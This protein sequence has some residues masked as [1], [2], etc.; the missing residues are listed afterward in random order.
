MNSPEIEGAADSGLSRVITAFTETGLI[1]TRPDPFVVR[2]AGKGGVAGKGFCHCPIPSCTTAKGK[3]KGRLRRLPKK[4]STMARDSKEVIA[5][6][7]RKS[8]IVI[9]NHR[10]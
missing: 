4:F 3:V 8:I 9:Y 10:R 2:L 5:A 6:E 7:M 1:A